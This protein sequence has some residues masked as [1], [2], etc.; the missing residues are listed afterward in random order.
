MR[1]TN[2]TPNLRRVRMA[3][4]ASKR[5]RTAIAGSVAAA[6]GVGPVPEDLEQDESIGAPII[7]H[8]LKGD[9]ADAYGNPAAAALVGGGGGLPVVANPFPGHVTQFNQFNYDSTTHGAAATVAAA[10]QTGNGTD[11]SNSSDYATP[12]AVGAHPGA[13]P[14]LNA[15]DFSLQPGANLIDGGQKGK[16]HLSN[17]NLCLCL[18]C[19]PTAPL[20]CYCCF[21]S[22]RRSCRPRI[23]C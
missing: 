7:K 16:H 1:T 18:S 13:A 17:H 3:P 22:C 14:G 20:F 8:E 10:G 23:F 2:T 19:S 21:G 9:T 15:E 5:P 4:P 11:T 12:A 6:P